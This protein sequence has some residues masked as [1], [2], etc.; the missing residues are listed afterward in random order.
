[1]ALYPAVRDALAATAEM[2]GCHVSHPYSSGASLYFTFLLR[3]GGDV[4]VEDRYLRTWRTAIEACHV[5]GGT[6][7]HHHGVGL[8]K[9]PYLRD[10]LGSEAM[11]LLRRIKDALDPQGILNPGKLFE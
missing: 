8:L 9:T 11:G 10:D 5:A 2:V 3:D 4:A 1:P 6:M 7:T